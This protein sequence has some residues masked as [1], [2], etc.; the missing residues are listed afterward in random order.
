MSDLFYIQDKFEKPSD[1]YFKDF[2]KELSGIEFPASNVERLIKS[3]IPATFGKGPE[4]VYDESYRKAST[5]N[6]FASTIDLFDIQERISRWLKISKEKSSLKFEPYKINIYEAGGFFNKH[7]DTPR[8]DDNIG[9][10]VICLPSEFTG[11]ELYIENDY[12]VKEFNWALESSTMHQWVAFYG[13]C[14]HWIN[15]VKAGTR[16]TITFNMYLKKY[17]EIPKLWEHNYK[18]YMTEYIKNRIN[19]FEKD[20]ENKYYGIPCRH[21]YNIS[22]LKKHGVKGKDLIIYDILKEI[23]KS[24]NIG[25]F[26]KK[27]YE[28]DDKNFDL[29]VKYYDVDVYGAYDLESEILYRPNISDGSEYLF[30]FDEICIN[31]SK[32]IDKDGRNVMNPKDINWIDMDISKFTCSASE[33]GIYGND[34]DSEERVYTSFFLLFE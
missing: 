30:N 15:P 8:G 34:P 11:G 7:K 24:C 32:D 28:G 27:W 17:I 2:K 13:D 22:T 31:D 26:I 25:T 23:R 21:E 18:E 9:T 16:V 19:Q 1:L 20:N 12:Y 5:I 29:H 6:N 33:R 14:N 10:L 4:E 3:S